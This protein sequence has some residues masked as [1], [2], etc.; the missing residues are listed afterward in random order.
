MMKNTGIEP[1]EF[2]SLMQNGN[3]VEKIMFIK[4]RLSIRTTVEY[5]NLMYGPIKSK[6]FDIV[7]SEKC[8][9]FSYD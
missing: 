3:W 7:R 5:E 6:R 4:E 1:G 8:L 9:I 2:I